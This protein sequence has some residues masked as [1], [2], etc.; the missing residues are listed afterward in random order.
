MKR[1]WEDKIAEV[2]RFIM[3][4]EATKTGSNVKNSYQK[5]Y[6]EMVS[7]S[8]PTTLVKDIPSEVIVCEKLQ[9]IIRSIGQQPKYTS[10]EKLL[11]QV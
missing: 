6:E 2:S 7:K 5:K 3:Q 1:K 9:S 8:N 10:I 11:D 4:I